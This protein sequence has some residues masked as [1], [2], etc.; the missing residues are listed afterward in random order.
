MLRVTVHSW[1]V[2]PLKVWRGGCGW[3]GIGVVRA[4]VGANAGEDFAG[5]KFGERVRTV[6]VRNDKYL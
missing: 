3:F 1:L 6:L 4:E 2:V 5:A